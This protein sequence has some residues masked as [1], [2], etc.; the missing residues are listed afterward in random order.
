MEQVLWS[1]AGNCTVICVLSSILHVKY[2]IMIMWTLTSLKERQIS[3][4]HVLTILAMV[5]ISLVSTPAYTR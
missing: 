3:V 5:S 4:Q 1:P 2:M